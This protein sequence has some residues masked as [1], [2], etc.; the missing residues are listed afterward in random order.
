VASI[1][2]GIESRDEH[3][4]KADYFNVKNHQYITLVSTSITKNSKNNYSVIANLV[5]KGKRKK[6]TIPVE[7]TKTE[8]NYKI[9]SNFEINRKDFDVGGGSL[10]MSKTVNINVVYFQDL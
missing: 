5:I 8:K 10:M 2:T 1:K 6:I 9:S 7:V 3:L 4:L